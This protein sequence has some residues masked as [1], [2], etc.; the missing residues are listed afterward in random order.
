MNGDLEE[1][2]HALEVA[3]NAERMKEGGV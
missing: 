2:I 3:E 1:I